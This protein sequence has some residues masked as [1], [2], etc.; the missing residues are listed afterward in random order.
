M[1]ILYRYG[2]YRCKYYKDT[3]KSVLQWPRSSQVGLVWKE[4]SFPAHWAVE[5]RHFVSTCNNSEARPWSCCDITPTWRFQVWTVNTRVYL[6]PCFSFRL[7]VEGINDMK[8]VFL[9]CYM[10]PLGN[11]FKI[12]N[13]DWVPAFSVFTSQA[14][15][16][17][18]PRWTWT[19]PCSV[20]KHRDV[21]SLLST[22]TPSSLRL[23]LHAA[24]HPMNLPP[25]DPTLK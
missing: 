16:T 11:S 20:F 25:V 24:G 3:G 22:P 19:R 18:S 17:H 9:G 14:P 10:S 6:A 7:C 5:S 4:K 23:E 12:I 15:P 1:W 21:W 8:T 13:Q 2:V